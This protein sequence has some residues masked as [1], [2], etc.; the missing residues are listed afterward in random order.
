MPR[1]K[2]KAAADALLSRLPFLPA[3]KIRLENGRFYLDIGD[4]ER[5]AHLVA[6]GWRKI[7]TLSYLVANGSIKKG[8]VL[9]WDEPETGLNP[10]LVIDLVQA[11]RQLAAAGVQIF[12]A[13]HDYLLAHQL[14]LRVER[15][16]KEPPVRFFSLHRQALKDPVSVEDADTLADITHNPI[17]QAYA[18]HAEEEENLVAEQSRRDLRGGDG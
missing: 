4:G 15:G 3:G 16:E 14:S 17:L 11:I 13:T 2:T 6:E 10:K 8:T 12:L 18:R 5:E 7:A 1:E 9:F